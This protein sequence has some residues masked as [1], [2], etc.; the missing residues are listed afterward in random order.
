M[1]RAALGA[2]ALTAVLMLIALGM[3][4]EYLVYW[5]ERVFGVA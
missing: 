4:V 5:L 3:S 1:S 2:A